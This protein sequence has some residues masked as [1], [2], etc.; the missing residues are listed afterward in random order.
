MPVI[1]K[2]EE[3]FGQHRFFVAETGTVEGQGQGKVCIVIVCTACGESR[4]LEHVVMGDN[5]QLNKKDK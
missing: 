5:V 4:L 3:C 1:T 2:P